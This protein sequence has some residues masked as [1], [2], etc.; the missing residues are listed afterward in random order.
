MAGVAIIEC[1]SVD[2]HGVIR[3]MQI[4]NDTCI[5]DGTIDGLKAVPHSL[6]VHECGDISQACE[7]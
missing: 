3:F 5:I 1:G 6:C 7:R 2:I 4:N